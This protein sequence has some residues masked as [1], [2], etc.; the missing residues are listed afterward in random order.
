MRIRLPR[1][2]DFHAHLRRGSA[3]G[4]Y[5]RREAGSFGRALVM[6]NTVPPIASGAEVEAY[7][8]EIL[9]AAPDLEP[10]M[11]FKLL[12]GM[13]SAAVLGCARAG[14]VAGKYY[15]AGSTTNAQ[16]GVGEPEAV[17]GELAAMEEA[18]LVLSIHPEEPSAPVLEREAAFL[19]RVEFILSRFPR[20]RVV[21]EHLST[22]AALEFVLAGP[23]RL[24]GTIT[25]HHL[26]FCLDDLLGDALDPWL[27][28]KPVLKPASDR[29]ALRDAVLS[30]R[31]GP[32]GAGESARLFFGS[33]S[34]PHARAAKEGRR[35]AS[36]VYSAPTALCALAALFEEAG[37]LDAL[38]D[39]VAVGGAAF[40]GLPPPS[41]SIELDRSAWTVPEELD[42]SVPML[43]GRELSWRIAGAE[44]HRGAR[45]D[46]S[47]LL[48]NPC[49]CQ[50]NS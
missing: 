34:A 33:D 42:G 31:G 23:E 14:A 4:A 49:Q 20:L 39:F 12:P 21:M 5:A 16:D 18:G 6:P 29:D 3:M 2:D 25:A 7:R 30:G 15:P 17:L 47:S 37:A 24:A 45:I 43:A 50:N 44:S 27:Y 11:A 10:L 48:H 28:C 36:G 1:P 38:R 8:A 9:A 22:R 35:A 40:Y 19:P 26:L 46:A 13:G 41:G 32:G